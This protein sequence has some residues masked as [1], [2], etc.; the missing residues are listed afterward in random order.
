M[1]HACRRHPSCTPQF[2]IKISQDLRVFRNSKLGMLE[3]C[4]L[5]MEPMLPSFYLSSW[6]WY[7]MVR[8]LD[9][10]CHLTILGNA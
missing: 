2:E 1:I 3:K 7:F 8:G 6:M 9:K 5:R 10:Y 4:V